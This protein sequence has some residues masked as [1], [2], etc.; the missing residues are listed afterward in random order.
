MS[1][2]TD[3]RSPL[4]VVQITDCHLGER[5][6]SVLLNLDTD[7]SL[8]AVLDL[9]RAQQPRIDA[10]LVTGDLSDQ[11]SAASY[12]RVLQA[13]R[14]LGEHA[15]WLPGNHDDPATLRKAL[16]TDARLQRNLLLGNWQIIMLDSS[17]RGE[18]GG[19][20]AAS[21]LDALQICLEAHPEH[22]ALICVHHQVL[23][24]GCEWLDRQRVANAEQLWNLLNNYPQVRAV[25]SGHVHQRFED[26]HNDVRVMTSPSTCVQFAPNSDDFRV[27]TEMPGY[28]W[29]E[30]HPNGRICTGVER[31][32]GCDSQVDLTATGY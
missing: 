21:E 19:F 5:V 20:L 9:V 28:R 29:F 14:D 2:S 26:M 11:G 10:L 18:V 22:F 25:L 30:L 16:G 15:R 12:R 17:V 13:T 24:V 23:P 6:G 4:R 3:Q 27:D 8:A 32:T 31:V 1:Q 7:Q